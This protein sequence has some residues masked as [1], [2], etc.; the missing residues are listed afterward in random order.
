M[1][2][3]RSPS[4][5][6]ETVKPPPPGARV[7]VGLKPEAAPGGPGSRGTR[8]SAV[9]SSEMPREAREAPSPRTRPRKMRRCWSSGVPVIGTSRRF[10][11]ARVAWR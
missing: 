9:P 2:D 11:S 6:A 3:G 1:S 7:T 4:K 5:R 8:W 10:R